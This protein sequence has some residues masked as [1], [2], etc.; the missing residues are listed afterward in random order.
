ML[1]KEA[2]P[3]SAAVTST[4]EQIKTNSSLNQPFAVVDDTDSGYIAKVS[5]KLLL[6][7]FS[8]S[9]S[10]GYKCASACLVT[11]QNYD[12]H[13]CVLYV[14]VHVGV[15]VQCAHAHGG[16]RSTLGSFLSPSLSYFL[17][18]SRRYG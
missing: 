6:P 4:G 15:C 14:H 13:V 16:Q 8:L 11:P 12:L 7:S 10:S 1:V 18:I 5:L 9:C 3:A 17:R 2:A